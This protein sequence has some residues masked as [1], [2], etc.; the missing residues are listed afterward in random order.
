MTTIERIA[1]DAP[2]MDRTLLFDTRAGLSDR[3]AI[4]EVVEKRA[5]ARHGFTPRPG[6]HWLDLGANVGAFTVWAAAHG[7]DVIA[8]EPDP[9]SM[10]MVHRNVALNHLEPMVRTVRAPCWPGHGGLGRR[11]R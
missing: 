4:R 1:I 8:F 11:C 3:K 2:R 9:E 7:A 5:Y 10:R 6:D